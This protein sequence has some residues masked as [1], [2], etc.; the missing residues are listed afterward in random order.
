MPLSAQLSCH[1]P[2][3]CIPVAPPPPPPPPPPPHASSKEPQSPPFISPEEKMIGQAT[4]NED[5][6]RTGSNSPVYENLAFHLKAK[7]SEP[8]AQGPGKPQLPQSSLLAARKALLPPPMRAQLDKLTPPTPVSQP[9]KGL[10]SNSN[11]SH[12]QELELTYDLPREEPEIEEHPFDPDYSY[13]IP[14]GTG[15]ELRHPGQVGNSKLPLK[16]G[17]APPLPPRPSFMKRFPEY[18]LLL[19][20]SSPTTPATPTAPPAPP[21]A[22][23]CPTP[24]LQDNLQLPG[25]PNVILVSLG[26]LV[27]DENVYTMYGEPTSCS[28]CGSALDSCYDNVV[29]MCYFCQSWESVT[30][31]ALHCPPMGCQ[32]C[33]FLLTSDDNSKSPAGSLLI[34]CI[35]ISGSMSITSQVTEGGRTIYKSRLQFVQQAV[36]QCV[37]R[38]SEEEPHTRVGLITFNNQVTLH[39]HGEVSSRFLCGPELIETDYLKEAAWSFPSPPP[40]SQSREQLEGEIRRLAESGATALGPATLI[41]IAMASRQ[42]GSKV[43]ICTDGKANTELG[44]LDVDESDARSLVSSTIFYQDLGEYAA[45]QG[46]TVSVLSIEGTDCRLDELGRLADRTAGKVVIARPDMLHSEFQKVMEKRTV[47]THCTVTLLLPTSLTVRG[48]RQGGH[49]GTREMGNVSADHEITF[50]FEAREQDTQALL[51]CGSVSVQLQIRYR[52]MDGQ[53]ALRVI[54]MDRRVTE[55]SSLVLSSLSLSILQLNS[56]QSSAALVVRGRYKDAQSE[57]ESQRRLMEKALD[58]IRSSEER[59][60]HKQWV[61]TMDP[62]YNNI[63]HYTR[64]NSVSF[65]DTQSL[66]DTGAVLLY[67]MKNS[68][69]MSISSKGGTKAHS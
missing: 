52:R 34:F 14:E 27:T 61:E 22:P 64:S 66:T 57:G 54:S 50:Q 69:R 53:R 24:A 58:H 3:N 63:Y 42:P 56:S 47:A 51:S 15:L 16:T 43:V 17:A 44:N 45:N 68:N 12:S 28:K 7:A 33:L 4:R 46:V 25:N 13:S 29:D 67:G 20:T 37:R 26:A 59:Q 21:S 18:V 9:Q 10:F 6:K 30:S 5:T 65:T 2:R 23:P 32:D 36:I 1:P 38:L 41:A 40:L 11:S 39:G 48:E 60:Q 31:P 19:P 55:E 8:A 49:K 35:D 62:I